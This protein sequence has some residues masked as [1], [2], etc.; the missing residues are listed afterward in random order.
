M[1]KYVIR[2]YRAI[3]FVQVTRQLEPGS[4]KGREEKGY[5]KAQERPGEKGEKGTPE[6]SG[7]KVGKSGNTGYKPQEKAAPIV[8]LVD[9]DL[10]A[11]FK[12]GESK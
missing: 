1:S 6:R 8:Y 12:Q 10:F 2:H 11:A 5:G 7:D 9:D 4:K 3:P